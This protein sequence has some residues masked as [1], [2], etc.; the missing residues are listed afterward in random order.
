MR[1][2]RLGQRKTSWQVEPNG[3]TGQAD[4][5]IAPTF[6]V[7]NKVR[8]RPSLTAAALDNPFDHPGGASKFMSVNGEETI[9][10]KPGMADDRQEK[11]QLTAI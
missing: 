9:M 8:L 2:N 3:S 6:D 7:P 5:T 4:G 11:R 10:V 1:G